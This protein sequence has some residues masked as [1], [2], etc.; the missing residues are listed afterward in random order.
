MSQPESEI[1]RRAV[2]IAAALAAADPGEKADARRMGPG[3]SALFW[4]QVTRLGIS[5]SQ[6]APWRAYTRLVA[7]M[8]PAS[9]DRSVHDAERPLGAAMAEAGLSEQ[10][11]ARLLAAR[12]PAREDAL[13]R[14]IRMIARKAPGVDVREL[15]QAILW[16]ADTGHLA[17]R[18]YEKT[19]HVKPEDTQDA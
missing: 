18:Y 9:R 4:R 10:R 12:G 1:A 8:T 14:A 3:G 15:A 19:D 7:L 2:A 16:P 6:E 5:P 11:F 17:R 13:E